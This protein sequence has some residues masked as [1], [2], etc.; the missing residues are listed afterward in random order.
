MT[1][2]N[3]ICVAPKH[4]LH[5][6][7]IRGVGAVKTSTWS[8]RVKNIIV[9]T[10]THALSSSTLHLL[11]IFGSSLPLRP[12]VIKAYQWALSAAPGDLRVNARLL[13]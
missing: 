10:H 6:F 5:F 7:Q 1:P 13:A 12:L 2:L 11:A 3:A 4:T 8:A 9:L